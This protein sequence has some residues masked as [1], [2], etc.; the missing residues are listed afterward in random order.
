MTTYDKIYHKGKQ[1]GIEQGIQQGIE[2]EKNKTIINAYDS[3]LTISMIANITGLSDQEV[4]RILIENGKN[5]V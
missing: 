4:Q 3:G 2:K 5:I 1:Q